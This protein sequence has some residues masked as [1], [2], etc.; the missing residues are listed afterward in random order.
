MVFSG[1]RS[2]SAI[3]GKRIVHGSPSGRHTVPFQRSF[4]APTSA[5]QG[6]RSPFALPAHMT[7]RDSGT[8][9]PVLSHLQV[10][11]PSL[12]QY[13]RN[14]TAENNPNCPQSMRSRRARCLTA[15][16]LIRDVPFAAP[17]KLVSTMEPVPVLTLNT[18][19]ELELPPPD[20]VP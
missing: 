18:V 1:T 4:C 11:L 12:E 5:A 10:T 7:I 20:A 19:P 9:A 17:A 2:S 14:S 15:S 6:A 13:E 16:T 3:F 8:S